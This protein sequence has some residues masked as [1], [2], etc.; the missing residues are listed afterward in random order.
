M[1]SKELKDIVK[2][3]KNLGVESDKIE[4]IGEFDKKIMKDSEL[5]SL[6]GEDFTEEE[7]M[8]LIGAIAVDIRGDW[9]YGSDVNG[10]L[11][12]IRDLCFVIG[13]GGSDYEIR[14][15]WDKA[16]EDGR[17][18][19]NEFS[20]YNFNGGMSNKKLLVMYKDTFSYPENVCTNGFDN[21]FEE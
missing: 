6:E 9:S 11:K 7:I 3:N 5:F 21:P 4:E 19:R 15:L 17:Y 18:L 8:E 14:E 12:T 1:I 2:K 10:R 16:S 13:D 20:G